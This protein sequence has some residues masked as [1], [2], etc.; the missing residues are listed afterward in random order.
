M[1]LY[2]YRA[3]ETGGIVRDGEIQAGDEAAALLALEEQGLLP[4][5]LVRAGAAARPAGSAA[6]GFRGRAGAKELITYTRQLETLLES[7]VSLTQSLGILADQTPC[8]PLRDATARVRER[9]EQGQAFAEALSAEPRIF[10]ALYVSM[11]QSG[12]EG[13]VMALMLE[14][15][16]TL[17]EHEFET[18]ERVK[19]AL[20]YPCLVLTELLIAMVV[21]VK[22]VL[23]RFATFFRTMG[24]ELPLPTRLMLGLSDFVE[25]NG[26]A[27]LVVAAAAITAVVLHVRTPRGRWQ[28]HTLQIRVP[29]LGDLILKT[30]MSRF[31]RAL[32]ALIASGV[33]ITVALLIIKRIVQNVVVEKEVSRMHEGIVQGRSITDSLRGSSVFPP[34]VVKMLAVGEETGSLDK[35]LMRVSSY[36]DRDVEYAVKNLTAAIEPLLLVVMGVSVLMVALAVFLPMW[37]LM[38]AVNH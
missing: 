28:F 14:R 26:V 32:A 7:G 10:P 3:R 5:R 15:T 13:G 36:F 37:N 16:A 12:E 22:L 17:M 1:A 30:I 23:P 24:A 20:F 4:I 33:P 21:L 11:V 35:M 8:V 9:V 27:I 31:A 2:Q 19:S 6:R 25:K 29:I 34:L 18:R 38:K